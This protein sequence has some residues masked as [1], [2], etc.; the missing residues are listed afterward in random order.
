MENKTINTLVK[1][2]KIQYTL[3]FVFPILVF[4]YGEFFAKD[5]ILDNP[6]NSSIT[7]LLQT[8]TV[9]LTMGLIPLS[10]K[11]FHWVL[12]KKIDKTKEKQAGKRYFLWSGIRL[13]LLEF[14]TLFALIVYYITQSSMGGLC[15]L[16]TITAALFCI[17]SK[18]RVIQEL[19]NVDYE[20]EEESEENE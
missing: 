13:A 10:L 1:N 12:T 11:L 20:T 9:V 7:Y 14:T 16:I 5:L 3:F 15:A 6:Q 4:I 17:P 18:N 2:L 19:T 8:L